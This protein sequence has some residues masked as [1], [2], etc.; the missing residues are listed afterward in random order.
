[1]T[2]FPDQERQETSH[3]DSKQTEKSEQQPRKEQSRLTEDDALCASSSAAMDIQSNASSSRNSS[4]KPGGYS[5]DE[6]SEISDECDTSSNPSS[7]HL[8]HTAANGG[9]SCDGG[10][11][12]S[13][14]AL[15][16]STTYTSGANSTSARH[17]M[18][19]NQMMS[20]NSKQTEGDASI[21]SNNISLTSKSVKDTQSIIMDQRPLLVNPVDPR[22]DLSCLNV[23]CAKEH[24]RRKY[25]QLEE[26]N[27]MR[28]PGLST[29]QTNDL[30]ETDSY[31]DAYSRLL[32]SC[33]PFFK[34]Y[35]EE[36][37]QQISPALPIT[38]SAMDTNHSLYSSKKKREYD[39]S[40]SVSSMIV[41]A[42][43]PK[44]RRKKIIDSQQQK[45]SQQTNQETKS[46]QSLNHHEERMH[47]NSST[48]LSSAPNSNSG[49]NQSSSC[50]SQ[51]S[52][53]AASSS[54]NRELLRLLERG[55]AALQH[56]QQVSSQSQVQ[57]E[58][59][60]NH[61]PHQGPKLVSESSGLNSA[62]ATG[63]GSGTGSGNDTYAAKQ[64]D[65][66]FTEMTMSG[67]T[68]SNSDALT[69][70]SNAPVI[71]HTLQSN[72]KHNNPRPTAPSSNAIDKE[73]TNADQERIAIKKRK[74]MDQRKE[75]EY[76]VRHQTQ[77]S[78][79][80]SIESVFK[81]GDNISMENSLSFTGTARLI[82]QAEPPYHIV[83]INAAFSR[84]TGIQNSSIIGKPVSQILSLVSTY[85]NNAKIMIQKNRLANTSIKGAQDQE[86]NHTKLTV[87]K[88]PIQG[89]EIEGTNLPVPATDALS[90][91]VDSEMASIDPLIASCGFH[92]YHQVR[93]R[94]IK[95]ILPPSSDGSNSN[96]GSN[97]SSI[98]SKDENVPKSCIMSICAVRSHSG[99]Q[100][101]TTFNHFKITTGTKQASSETPSHY[102]I[103]LF[104]LEGKQIVPDN[105]SQTLNQSS[106][107]SSRLDD[108]SQMSGTSTASKP[109]VACG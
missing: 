48:K 81:P 40:D 29:S 43:R 70:T 8:I 44:N 80:S 72:H 39:E 13:V 50:S 97:N 74:R 30:D 60:C 33:Q 32:E 79:D 12:S 24:D 1:M 55:T 107:S 4:S 82:V 31:L 3:D 38:V 67:D 35:Q 19:T 49:M 34:I 10:G 95:Q 75:I 16:S 11:S 65:I 108:D 22:I 88:D 23:I 37:K 83:H 62:S 109:V 46:K 78:S 59:E 68:N 9:S 57:N 42:P 73:K 36:L 71:K 99:S 25:E 51:S 47:I 41:L 54:Q 85:D 2:S 61:I 56:R 87:S 106:T 103:Q 18:S 53:S 20:A 21:S 66:N 69:K 63:T 28:S 76:M 77:T 84:L 104:P 98:S 14:R 94:D 96:N 93:T 102:L 91:N 100:R 52:S 15:P 89:M 7:C 92:R 64:Y 45:Q 101:S 86:P 58:V 105:I 27:S 5:G 17:V 26:N 90:S 6:S